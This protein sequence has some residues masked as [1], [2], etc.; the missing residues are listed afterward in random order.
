MTRIAAISLIL[1]LAAPA[2]IA[3]P[4]LRDVSE[5]DDA[6][7]AVG[8][9]NEIRKQCPSI[10]ARKIKALMTLQKLKS[11]AN[12]LGYSDAEIE[13]YTSSEAE[14]DRMRARGAHWFGQQGIDTS[15]PEGYCVA[16]R[17]EIDKNSQIG[18]LL[19]AN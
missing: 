9:A 12:E 1:A 8:L 17:S 7:F 4:H 13:A 10:S 19:K 11:R 2:A 5:I 15:T 16:G 14:K 3:K 6:L 18:A